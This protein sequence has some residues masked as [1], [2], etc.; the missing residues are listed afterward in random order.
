MDVQP[1]PSLNH[2]TPLVQQFLQQQQQQQQ[3]HIIPINNANV[4]APT[5]D[6][7]D[8]WRALSV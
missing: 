1:L 7:T 5:E 8:S 3:Q 2:F 6:N 4:A